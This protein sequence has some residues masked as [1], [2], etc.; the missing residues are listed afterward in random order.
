[1]LRNGR[2]PIKG[3]PTPWKAA[4]VLFLP[5][6][7]VV[8]GACL[9]LALAAVSAGVDPTDIVLGFLSDVPAAG[10]DLWHRLLAIW[11]VYALLYTIV[12]VDFRAMAKL[13]WTGRLL[14]AHD[15]A[16]I[17][18]SPLVCTVSHAPPHVA[19]SE[20]SYAQRIVLGDGWS[21]GVHPQIE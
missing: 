17:S 16:S 21:P 18:K 5:G 8:G 9:L 3:F 13:S 12:V 14:L 7:W 20:V 10:E 6:V 1:M 4:K 15:L 11:V 2:I 19:I